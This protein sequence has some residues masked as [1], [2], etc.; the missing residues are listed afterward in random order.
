MLITSSASFQT[1]SQ[2]SR[3]VIAGLNNVEI[4]NTIG[5]NSPG[6]ILLQIASVSGDLSILSGSVESSGWLETG[7]SIVLAGR[8]VT[9]IARE[10]GISYPSLKDWKRHYHGDAVPQREDLAA[11]NR[12]LKA[13]LNRVREQRDILKKTLGIFTE[14]SP[15]VTKPSKA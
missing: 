12:A 3:I 15:S 14:P 6:L 7:A 2:G 1:L 4:G 5:K 13:E 9:Q 10:L 8:D 11:E